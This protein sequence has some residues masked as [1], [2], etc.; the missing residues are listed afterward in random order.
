VADAGVSH[1]VADAVGALL[2]AVVGRDVEQLGGLGAE[3]PGTVVGDGGVD[4]LGAEHD[5]QVGRQ[6][7]GRDRVGGIEVEVL[8]DHGH[9]LAGIDQGL[10]V[11]GG[12]TSGDGCG[13][14]IHGSHVGNLLGKKRIV[15]GVRRGRGGLGSNRRAVANQVGVAALA[16]C[17]HVSTGNSHVLVVGSAIHGEGLS[18]VVDDRVGSLGSVRGL[19]HISAGHQQVVVE[20]LR[21]VSLSVVRRVAG[22]GVDDS[23]DVLD[24]VL[25]RQGGK[26]GLGHSGDQ[27]GQQDKKLCD[28]FNFQVF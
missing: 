14:G 24:H 22:V 18:V 6:L 2:A 8:L 4:E 15:H 13:A 9:G 25:A 12:V 17:D 26:G 23:I 11:A 7:G 19:G 28:H 27:N 10:P 3:S 16:V 20:V 1:V 21:A 5:V